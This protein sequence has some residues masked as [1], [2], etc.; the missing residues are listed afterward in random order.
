MGIPARAQVSNR[1]HADIYNGLP[2]NNVYNTHID[3][4]GYLWLCTDKGLLRYNGYEFTLYTTADGLPRNDVWWMHMDRKGRFWVCSIAHGFGYI[5]NNRYHKA[6]CPDPAILY[7]Q[8]VSDYDEGIWFP[9]E[10]DRKGIARI[11]V[12]HNDTLRFLP[13]NEGKHL[14]SSLAGE[15]VVDSSGYLRFYRM[16][17]E[18]AQLVRTIKN[19]LPVVWY[20]MITRKNELVQSVP[21]SDK[22]IIAQLDSPWHRKELVFPDGAGRL[23]TIRMIAWSPDDTNIVFMARDLYLLDT[24]FRIAKKYSYKELTGSDAAADDN[25]VSFLLFDGLWNNSVST[26]NKGMFINFVTDKGMEP[27]RGAGLTGYIC[28]GSTDSN[29]CWWWHRQSRTLISVDGQGR[30]TRGRYPELYDLLR[31]LP[32]DKDRYLVYDK[33]HLYWLRRSDLSLKRIVAHW[34]NADGSPDPERAKAPL[35]IHIPYSR[36]VLLLD[37]GRIYFSGRG[38][39]L[40]LLG[41]DTVKVR[42]VGDFQFH[43]DYDPFRKAYWS[44]YSDRIMFHPLVGSS[45]MMSDTAFRRFGITTIEKLF[46]DKQFG[47]LLLKD[48]NNL[49]CIDFDNRNVRSLFPQYNL[50][51]A[52]FFVRSGRIVLAGKFGVLFSRILGRNRFSNP[53]VYENVKNSI[54]S[55]VLDAGFAGNRMDLLTDRGTFVIRMP[56]DSDFFTKGT[57]VYPYNIVL[58]YRDTLYNMRQL[59]TLPVVATDNRIGIDVI[60]PRGNGTLVRYARIEE[61]N[62][63]WQRIDGHELLLPRLEAGRIYTLSLMAS[64]EVWKSAPASIKLYLVPQWW[65]RPKGKLFLWSYTGLTILMLLLELVLLTRYLVIRSARKKQLMTSLS[66]RAVYAQIN[67]HFIFNTLNT[68]LYFIRKRQFDEAATHVTRFSHLLRAYLHSS[69]NRY[70]TIEEEVTNLNNYIRLQQTRF[71]DVF[72]HSIQVEDSVPKHTLSIPSL[73]LQP[74]VENAIN[75]GLVPKGAGGILDIRFSWDEENK[76]LSCVIDDNGVGRRHARKTGNHDIQ[77]KESYGSDLIRELVRIFNQY[78]KLGI[79]IRYIDKEAPLSGTQVIIR[80]KKP[81][82]E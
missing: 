18:G 21:F 37:P 52:R 48:E 59:E 40:G 73:L 8:G 78:E 42:R 71:D 30:T 28:V 31:I 79:D 58:E 11:C 15:L 2:S 35:P 17:A 33:S 36:E 24:A 32:Y 66:L 72:T 80:I 6:V 82:H 29:T 63:G 14:V 45:T 65:Q 67:P 34:I 4:M 56:A 25:S 16:R 61:L 38:L 26:Y 5:K 1:F 69:R 12:E 64:D 23:Q 10:D 75:H 50:K 77:K 76:Y 46:V 3:S 7:P 70:I 27:S 19:S 49:Y 41:K 51:D 55:M 20:S 57:N 81:R 13:A 43:M 22:I 60:N 44:Y 39:Y 68:A 62:S 53:V 74:I 9:S 54:Y 47:N